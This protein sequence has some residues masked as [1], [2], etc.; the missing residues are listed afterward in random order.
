VA[1]AFD[2]VAERD[3]VVPQV[4]LGMIERVADAGCA[5]RWIT[6]V[7]PSRKRVAA[8]VWSLRSV[9]AKRNRGWA[10]SRA[11]RASLSATS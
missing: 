4:G 6:S 10:M 1:A 5:A 3:E 2:H 9:G 8:A 7:K 11:S